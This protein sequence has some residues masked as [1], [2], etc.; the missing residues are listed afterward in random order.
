M[1]KKVF[2][3]KYSKTPIDEAIEE[4]IKEIEEEVIEEPVKVEEPKKRGRKKSVK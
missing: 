1:K 4:I 3:E 2:R